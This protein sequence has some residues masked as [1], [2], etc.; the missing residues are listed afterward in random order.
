MRIRK[1]GVVGSGVMGGAI[2]ALTASAGVPVVLLDIPAGADEKDRNAPV[3]RGL[4]RAMKARPAAF[5]DARRAALIELGNIEDDLGKLAECDWIVEAIVERL[6]P[7]QALYAKL[8]DLRGPETIITSNTSGI[9]MAQLTAGRSEGFRR[10]FFGTH[11]FNPP[12][13]LHLLELIP[14]PETD[15]EAIAAVEWFGQ[16]ILGKGT[17]HAKDVP[18]FIGN[19]IGGYAMR[20]AIRLMEELDLTIDEV[21]TLTGP[22]VGRPRSATFRTADLAGLDVMLLVSQDMART[23]GSSH[24]LPSWIEALVAR[25]DLGEKTGAGCYKR[26]GRGEILTLNWKT[27]EYGPRQEVRSPELDALRRLPLE[28]RLKGVTELPGAYGAF[29]RKLATHVAHFTLSNAEEIAYDI[30]SID[31]AMEWGW[32]WEL[33]PFRQM[34]ALGLDT[35]R[36]AFHAEGLAEPALLSQAGERFY[37]KDAA[38]TQVLGLDGVYRALAPRAGVLSL[39]DVREAGGMVQESRSASLLDLGDGVLLLEFHTKMNAIDD[40]IV[41]ALESATDIATRGGWAGLVIGN[42]DPQAFSAGANIALMLEAARSGNLAAIDAASRRFQ[43]ANLGLR[44]AP[45]PVVAAVAGLALGGGAEVALHADQVVAAGEAYIGLVEVGVGL[46]PAGGGCKE[47]LFRFTQEL[48]PYIEADPFE[49][50]RRA[51]MLIGLGTTSSSAIDARTLGFLRPADRI[52]MN[53]DYLLADA[54]AAVLSLARDYIA[55]IPPTIT[56]LGRD[57]LGNLRAAVWTMREAGQ[58]SEHDALIGNEL[59]YVLAAGDGPPRT[60]REKDLL[61]LEREAFTRLAATEKTQ[62]RLEHMLATGK[63]LRN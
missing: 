15:P 14:T 45:F 18:A 58:I 26:E 50:A 27:L 35:L 34:D 51:F 8:D 12:R 61:D 6:E 23:H 52:T 21:D 63:P 29:A 7:K 10:H 24:A 31:R 22:L 33:G 49:A 42:E 40:D 17:V 20:E 25:G 53:R 19:R 11:F 28:Q 44:Y 37:T 48:Q 60:V 57:A 32:A 47:L 54:K 4:D 62:Q 3:K 16:R 30:P 39:A 59:A 55:P 43:Q 41:A 36:A 9:P 2:A 5:M 38:G 1:V 13:Y 46:I 56:A